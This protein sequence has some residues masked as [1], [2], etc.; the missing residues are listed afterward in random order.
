MRV[1]RANTHRL[2]FAKL[3]AQIIFFLL[4]ENNF[5][6]F[7]LDSVVWIIVR[8]RDSHYIADLM[9]VPD[10]D[11]VYIKNLEELVSEFLYQSSQKDIRK[12]NFLLKTFLLIGWISLVCRMTASL[13][14]WILQIPKYTFSILLD[15]CH[16]EK[17]KIFWGT[18]FRITNWI[19]MN[20]KKFTSVIL[21]VQLSLAFGLFNLKFFIGQLISGI[22]CL[23]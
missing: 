16:A 9:N 18:V 11:N 4:I 23:K 13:N 21:N 14:V 19:M 1:K 20:G 12:Y 8:Q 2:F 17:A 15:K 10:P 3:K 22:S 7:F 6:L 5:R